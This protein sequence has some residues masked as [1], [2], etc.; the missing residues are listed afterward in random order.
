VETSATW[1]LWQI[2]LTIDTRGF[3]G[4]GSK[5]SGDFLDAV[6]I[7]VASALASGG[8]VP[9]PTLVSFTATSP[10]NPSLNA[11]NWAAPGKGGLNAS[12]CDGNGSGFICDDYNQ[13]QKKVPGVPVTAVYSWTFDIP[14]A[15]GGLFTGSTDATIKASYVNASGNKVGALVSQNIQLTP[16]PLVPTPEPI[17]LIAL[18]TVLAGTCWK[19]GKRCRP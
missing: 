17:S 4:D 19:F 3:N 1:D 18:I 5:S 8:G 11:S 15:I 7:K 6:S 10:S 13:T 2:T 9:A 16:S 12:G 14:V